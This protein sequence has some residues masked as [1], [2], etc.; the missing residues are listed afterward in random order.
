MKQEGGKNYH[1]FLLNLKPKVWYYTAGTQGTFEVL[2]LNNK[3]NCA[4]LL[5]KSFLGLGVRIHNTGR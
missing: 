1:K 2:L 4:K 5:L 3:H